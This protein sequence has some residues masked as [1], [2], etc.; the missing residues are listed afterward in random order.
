MSSLLHSKK[1]TVISAISQF[2]HFVHLVS[3]VLQCPATWASFLWRKKWSGRRQYSNSVL[4]KSIYLL[5][6]AYRYKKRFNYFTAL[7][8]SSL[9]SFQSIRCNRKLGC[10]SARFSSFLV[11][12]LPLLQSSAVWDFSLSFILFIDNK[13]QIKIY[14]LKQ[15][16]LNER[17]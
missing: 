16:E 15:F 13:N 1:I 3:H 5:M 17:L 11:W 8:W 12:L 7:L 2:Q 14:G 9:I 6:C 4:I 10:N